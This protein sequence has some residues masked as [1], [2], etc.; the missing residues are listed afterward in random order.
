VTR[1]TTFLIAFLLFAN[2]SF[3]QEKKLKV[4]ISADMEGVGGVSTW[5]VQASAKG[6]E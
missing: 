3:A 5:D 6:R 2:A 4:Y 1:Q